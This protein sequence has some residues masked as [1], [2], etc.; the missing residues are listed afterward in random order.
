MS[1]KTFKIQNIVSIELR[2]GGCYLILRDGDD[3]HQIKIS[4]STASKLSYEERIN[5][6]KERITNEKTRQR[7]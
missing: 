3:L 6:A 2:G 5:R 1:N 4:S 7:V